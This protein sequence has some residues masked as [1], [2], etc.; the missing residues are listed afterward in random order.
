MTIFP[1]RRCGTVPEVKPGKPDRHGRI[2]SMCIEHDC[3]NGRTYKIEFCE[4]YPEE[5]RDDCI[6]RWNEDNARDD[7]RWWPERYDFL[8]SVCKTAREEEP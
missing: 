6:Y 4:P 1:C 7:P 5:C 8:R 3:R 2:F